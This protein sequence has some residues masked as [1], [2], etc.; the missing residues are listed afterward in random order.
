[1]AT[2]RI[3]QATATVQ[4]FVQRCILGLEP[5][6]IRRRRRSTP[7]GPNGEWM[8]QYRVWQAN[9]EVF[10][11]PE[12]WIDPSLRANKSPFFADLEQEL[13]QSDVTSDVV[14]T[15]LGH[16]LEKLEAVAR[17]DVCGHLP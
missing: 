4:L 7:T 14:E 17:L 9:R 1:M 11:F 2:S 15:A 13:K 5:S 16:Y 12:N 3:V 8:S 10:L 6:V